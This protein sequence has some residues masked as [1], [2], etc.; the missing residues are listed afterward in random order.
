MF[1]IGVF[2]AA[3]L[4]QTPAPKDDVQRQLE[5]VASTFEE[6]ARSGK[7]DIGLMKLK[8]AKAGYRSITLFID[9]Y[10]KLDEPRIKKLRDQLSSNNCSTAT[11]V[12]WLTENHVT[13]QVQF[14]SVTGQHLTIPIQ[15]TVCAA[16]ADTGGVTPTMPN[17][18]TFQ[19]KEATAGITLD[20][21]R[22][23]GCSRPDKSGETYCETSDGAVGNY[24][25]LPALFTLYNGR[26]TSLTYGFDPSAFLS[27]VQSFQTKYGK[28][29]SVQK[30]PWQNAAGARLENVVV[31]WCFSTG[32]MEVRHISSRI[33]MGSASYFDD[34]QAPSSKPSINF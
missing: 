31:V 20:V 13:Y 9:V 21:K 16:P 27:I 6:M 7:G 12:N 15:P 4:A 22:L 32:K 8:G 26:L 30:E 5:T 23:K 17:L 24:N 19:F 14:T 3:A 10:I 28:P 1:S 34:Y 2:L 29:C 25:G 18:R 33:D 11:A